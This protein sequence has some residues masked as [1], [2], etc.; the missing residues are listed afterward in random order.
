MTDKVIG[1]ALKMGFFFGVA[2]LVTAWDWNIA[3]MILAVLVLGS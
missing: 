1:A 2:Y 3:W